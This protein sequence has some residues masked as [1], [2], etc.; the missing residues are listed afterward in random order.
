LLAVTT[1]RHGDVVRVSIEDNGPGMAA[2]SGDVLLGPSL[3]SLSPLHGVGFGMQVCRSIVEEAGGVVRVSN[4][5]GKGTTYV[6]ELPCGNDAVEGG[7][8]SAVR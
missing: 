1:E 5:Q 6:V 8:T 7:S 2:G 3:S 4:E